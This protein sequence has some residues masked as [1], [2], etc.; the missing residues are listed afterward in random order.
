MQGTPTTV[1]EVAAA[2]GETALAVATA[3]VLLPAALLGSTR[4]AAL[5]PLLAHTVYS[6]KISAGHHPHLRKLVRSILRDACP[7]GASQP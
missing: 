2:V 6:S 4:P 1:A 7:P 3:S 5:K